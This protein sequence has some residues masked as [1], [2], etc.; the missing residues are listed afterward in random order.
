MGKGPPLESVV[1]A[2]E[3]PDLLRH[4]SP[5]HLQELDGW[6]AFEIHETASRSAPTIATQ[7][8]VSEYSGS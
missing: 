1:I 2:N 8:C 4:R 7:S 3:G 6:L 5:S